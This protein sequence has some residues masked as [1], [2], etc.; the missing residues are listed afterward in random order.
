[1]PAISMPAISMPAISMPA[2]SG[3]AD[4]SASVAAIH[5]GRAVRARTR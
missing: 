4:A 5:S 1:M 2:I 3:R